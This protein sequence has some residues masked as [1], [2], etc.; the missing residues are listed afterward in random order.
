MIPKIINILLRRRHFWRS[1]SFS[2]IAELYSSR[3][4]RVIALNLGAGFASVYL[5][6]L[7]YSLVA[8]TVFWALYFVYRFVIA[9]PA[10]HFTAYYGPKHGIYISSLMYIPAM[11]FLATLPQL[12]IFSV[13]GWGIFM[14]ASVTLYNLCFLVDFSKVKD[15][16]HSG[17]ELGYMHILEKIALALS[18]ILGGGIAL[19]A[20]P[21]I[22]MWIAS[23]AL[24]VACVPLMSSSEPTKTHQKIEYRGFPWKN[25]KRTLLAEFAVGYDIVATTTIWGLHLAVSIFATSGKAIYVSLGILSGATVIVGL[26]AAYIYGKM[27]D[28]NRGGRLLKYASIANGLTH[29]ARPL[30]NTPIGVLFINLSNEIATT[31]VNMSRLRG[32]FD[33]ADSTGFRILYLTIAEMISI[34]GAATASVIAC[35]LL[36]LITDADAAF[37]WFYVI[38]AP[39]VITIATSRFKI[40]S[41]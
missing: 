38:A 33:T 17:K 31:G 25:V 20:S 16:N 23:F 9:I 19:V 11:V 27:I 15:V 7:G 26:V 18:P 37:S 14:G 30:V 35:V 21:E 41:K 8:I 2:E 40:Y 12:G 5:Y 34:L 3:T 29:A 32:L 28:S 1:V 6:E 10:A 24:I 39:V 13:I 22:V 36:S 4:M